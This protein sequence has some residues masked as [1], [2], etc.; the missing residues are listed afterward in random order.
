MEYSTNDLM[1]AIIDPRDATARGF[2]RIDRRFDEL[3]N[4]LKDEMNRRIGAL[5]QGR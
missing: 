2:E 1:A 4:E 3:K 5:E